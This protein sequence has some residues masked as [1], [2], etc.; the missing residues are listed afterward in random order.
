M[1]PLGGSRKNVLLGVQREQT[2]KRE[3]GSKSGSHLPESQNAKKSRRGKRALGRSKTVARVD[4]R[5]AVKAK[6]SGAC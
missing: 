1:D 5:V 3:K 4:A 6:S 2:G